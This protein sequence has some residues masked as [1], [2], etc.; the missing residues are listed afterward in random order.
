[1]SITL[2]E[3]IE[4]QRAILFEKNNLEN[5]YMALL[6]KLPLNLRS[7]QKKMDDIER[8]IR[9][10]ELRLQNINKEIL[11]LQNK[12][13]IKPQPISKR[14]KRRAQDV[15]P[16]APV[17]SPPRTN[18]NTPP[19]VIAPEMEEEEEVL[20]ERHQPSTLTVTS[21]SN[22]TSSRNSDFLTEPFKSYIT[23]DAVL[24]DIYNRHRNWW[25]Y[26]TGEFYFIDPPVADAII[27]EMTH[28][29]EQWAQV[30]LAKLE[31]LIDKYT[32]TA[33]HLGDL[34]EDIKSQMKDYFRRE[35]DIPTNLFTNFFNITYNYLMIDYQ[36]D[37][38]RPMYDF[39]SWLLEKRLNEEE[40]PDQLETGR[41]LKK[42]EDAY[43]KVD[44]DFI[45]SQMEIHLNN[46]LKGLM[47]W[48]DR[49]GKPFI[50]DK[51]KISFRA[52]NI[53]DNVPF[54][55]KAIVKPGNYEF[56]ISNKAIREASP[57]TIAMY[58]AVLD[59]SSDELY[60]KAEIDL[61]ETL[62]AYNIAK[63][64]TLQDIQTL[65]EELLFPLNTAVQIQ[66]QD[67]LINKIAFVRE[68]NDM[69]GNIESQLLE[70]YY[71]RVAFAPAEERDFIAENTAPPMSTGLSSPILFSDSFQEKAVLLNIEDE[72]VLPHISKK[73]GLVKYVRIILKLDT[74]IEYSFANAFRFLFRACQLAKIYNCLFKG[75]SVLIKFKMWGIDKANRA[76]RQFSKWVTL[77]EIHY[78]NNTLPVE[79]YA[80][81]FYN[82]FTTTVHDLWNAVPSEDFEPISIMSSESYWFNR[83]QFP[84]AK[85]KYKKYPT[86]P[87]PPGIPP[88]YS[89]PPPP[90][91]SPDLSSFQPLTDEEMA[92]LNQIEMNSPPS[93][94]PNTSIN[95]DVLNLDWSDFDLENL[96]FSEL[97]SS[98]EKK[99]KS[100]DN[101]DS[102]GH[103]KRKKPKGGGWC[104]EKRGCQQMIHGYVLESA[105]GKNG[106]CFFRAINNSIGKQVTPIKNKGAKI[107]EVC[108]RYL[109]ENNFEEI[110]ILNGVTIQNAIDLRLYL[111]VD[112]MIYEFD[113]DN[114]LKNIADTR[115]LLPFPPTN[116]GT[117]HIVL[118]EGH[119]YKLCSKQ[120]YDPPKETYCSNCRKYFVN[121]DKHNCSEYI[122]CEDCG[123]MRKDLTNHECNIKEANFFANKYKEKIFNE[124]QLTAN[125]L[126]VDEYI[127]CK[128]TIIYDLETLIDDHDEHKP[129]ACGWILENELGQ[130]REEF[131]FE[132]GYYCLFR[133]LDFLWKYELETD[134]KNSNFFVIGYN[135]SGYDNHFILHEII[136]RKYKVNFLLQPGGNLVTMELNNPHGIKFKFL[137]IFRFLVQGT[138]RSNALSFGLKIQK[139]EFPYEFVNSY[140]NIYYNGP[141]PDVEYWP[142]D[143]NEE[144]EPFP[145]I[146]DNYQEIKNSGTN[147]NMQEECIKYLEKDVKATKEIYQILSTVIFEEFHVDIRNFVTLSHMAYDIWK[148][149]FTPNL[150]FQ[151]AKKWYLN[152]LRPTVTNR[153]II[154]LPTVPQYIFIIQGTY[155]GRVGPNK[156]FF[157]HPLY[158]QIMKK[159]VKYEEV[160]KDYLVPIDVTGLYPR[161]MENFFYPV[162]DCF[163]T[164]EEYIELLNE[165]FNSEN[166]KYDLET[167]LQWISDFRNFK[168]GFY[169]VNYY[170]PKNLIVPILPYKELKFTPYGETRSGRIE[171]NLENRFH[172][173]YTSTEIILAYKHGYQFEILEGIYWEKQEKIFEKFINHVVKLKEYAEQ[174]KK[175]SLRHFAKTL[176][177][178]LFGKMLQKPIIESVAVINEFEEFDKFLEEYPFITDIITFTDRNDND[179]AILKAKTKEYQ[180]QI[181]KPSQLG[182][183]VLSYSRWIM[184]EY[185]N[186]FDP[187]RF[188]N[189]K[190][191]LENTFWYGDT[192]SLFVKTNDQ[193]LNDLHEQ[194]IYNTGK[195]GGIM[196]DDKDHQGKVI[197]GI[198]LSRKCYFHL[199]L[200][201]DNK[202]RKVAKRAGIPKRLLTPELYEN[203]L[204][205]MKSTELKLKSRFKKSNAGVFEELTPF[206]IM[207]QDMT[208]TFNASIEE[209][210]D[211]F[212][213]IDDDEHF[214]DKPSVPFGFDYNLLE[215][216]EIFLDKEDEEFIINLLSLQE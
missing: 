57:N 165:I 131:H 136:V 208:R 60:T 187:D 36:N 141:I 51:Y 18:A 13:K 119:W 198:Y 81:N 1:M 174:T 56:D 117:A 138:L 98:Q 107:W 90:Y 144:D 35:D 182:A 122:G 213:F 91:T 175:K 8:R 120:I 103:G 148:A 22:P 127:S 41:R 155:G 93:T 42:C 25:N 83:W 214:P 211:F 46:Y 105:R 126:F 34:I 49:I 147:W 143:Y 27:H 111:C 6:E 162:G 64:E 113:E 77:D 207:T 209:G 171:Y 156:L 199:L 203:A 125:I 178:A 79:N 76:R 75:G 23:S 114:I 194:G 104:A 9:S 52:S 24:D 69:I 152:C 112:L 53:S 88:P 133:F 158:D 206:K 11:K 161:A 82:I 106:E 33:Y 118:F 189:A 109:R 153:T 200:G 26:F 163:H 40:E 124:K 188:T 4:S 5:E 30:M 62:G 32:Y 19:G 132:Y 139:G 101:N 92:I 20:S 169:R 87:P 151:S 63:Q 3:L 44:H 84:N 210:R 29:P 70:Y 212:H 47:E 157:K 80:F 154:K 180:L 192:D 130:H 123:A 28:N 170:P 71:F 96:D 140:G 185:Y 116:Y 7:T 173:V 142:V 115:L 38:F 74:P 85:I 121:I 190:K 55:F 176:M 39:L 177:N 168:M 110:N 73:T 150:N 72:Q 12:E 31:E 167:T 181:T 67:E 78:K 65:K 196:N 129:Y 59:K 15:R 184:Q 48:L 86:I 94:N 202:I 68:L 128:N 166:P 137:D 66:K 146:P 160:T 14:R 2:E 97:Y 204:F 54:H 37:A 58:D 17:I 164:T 102:S 95:T 179:H 99:R 21:S 100:N 205:K 215:E 145:Q 10:L 159:E 45:L 149:F 172:C 50:M 197:Y 183:F 43:D 191:S 195:L 201:K 135:N 186:L 216:K 134:C 193:Q 61:Q 108:N 16:Y 89:S